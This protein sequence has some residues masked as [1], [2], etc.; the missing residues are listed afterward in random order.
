MSNIATF[1]AENIIQYHKELI[2][3][4]GL[5]G[6]HQD[7]LEGIISRVDARI[8]YKEMDDV[9]E[10]AALYMVAIAKGH[11]FNDGNKRTAL[12]ISLAFLKFHR[13]DI[14]VG[15]GLNDLVVQVAGWTEDDQDELIKLVS[16]QLYL[17]AE[18]NNQLL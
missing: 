4:G 2:K 16:Y 10:I 8:D 7:K 18:D 13:I 3:L 12:A 11:A 6:V 17:L 1:T 5:S 14:P 15:S 9:L